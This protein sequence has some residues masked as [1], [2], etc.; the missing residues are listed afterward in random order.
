VIATHVW[1]TKLAENNG[2]FPQWKNCG[3]IGM[4]H[5]RPHILKLHTVT[6]RYNRYDAY[7]TCF[8]IRYNYANNEC[9][10]LVFGRVSIENIAVDAG[11][12]RNPLPILLPGEQKQAACFCSKRPE[13]ISKWERGNSLHFQSTYI[14]EFS[15]FYI[16][17]RN[18]PNSLYVNIIYLPTDPISLVFALPTR[19]R[20]RV[21]YIVS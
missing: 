15:Q 18:F 6:L 17:A 21:I 11:M 10:S 13:T 12:F 2:F 5:T 3:T 1:Y 14:W 8:A 16:C 4:M 7:E 9:F 19:E 20:C